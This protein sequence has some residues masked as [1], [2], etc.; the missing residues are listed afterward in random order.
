[1]TQTDLY[2]EIVPQNKPSRYIAL[3]QF[4]DSVLI[5]GRS[6][7]HSHIVL[8]DQ[9]ISRVHLRLSFSPEGELLVADLHSANGTNME[10]MKLPPNINVPWIAGQMITIGAT[11]MFLW[12][13]GPG[14]TQI[15]E[16]AVG[17][18]TAFEVEAW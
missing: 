11:R 18:E 1:M 8:E 16:T 10:G 12:Q 14:E 13:R 4:D 9:R 3:D 5:V 6:K 15:E 7:R 2:L 17:E